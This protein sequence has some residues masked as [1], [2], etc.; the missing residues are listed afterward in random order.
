MTDERFIISLSLSFLSLSCQPNSLANGS[1]MH[2]LRDI[3]HSTIYF[4]FFF[5]FIH[6]SDFVLENVHNFSCKVNRIRAFI[7]FVTFNIN[8]ECK[9]GLIIEILRERRQF[10]YF[11]KYL[12]DDNKLPCVGHS[13]RV[14]YV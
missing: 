9:L 7:R 13:R 3:A 5:K 12:Y 11:R 10:N 6:V 14:F 1:S 8:P 4:M 2:A